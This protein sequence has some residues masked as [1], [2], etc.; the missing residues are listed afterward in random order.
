MMT[1]NEVSTYS[2]SSLARPSAEVVH[3]GA[4]V[5]GRD[6]DAQQAEVGHLGQDVGVKPVFAVQILDPRRNFARRPF[7]D[8][9][10]EEAMFVRKAKVHSSDAN[11]CLY[12]QR[13]ADGTQQRLA[14]AVRRQ[15]AFIRVERAR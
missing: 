3:P 2:S 4:A 5:L 15:A 12:R 14:L 8:R 10:F 6:A 7:A 11:T 1:R 13:L 9:L